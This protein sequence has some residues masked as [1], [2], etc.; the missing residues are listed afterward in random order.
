[1]KPYVPPAVITAAVAGLIVDRSHMAAREHDQQIETAFR[2]SHVYR[3]YLRH[4]AVNISVKEG[5]VFLTGTVSND[6]HRI[7]AEEMAAHLCGV[8]RVNNYLTTD[9]HKES[10]TPSASQDRRITRHVLATLLFH[11]SVSASSTNVEVSDGVVTL[12]GDATSEAQRELTAAYAL[13][14]DGVISIDNQMVVSQSENSADL[15]D[16]QNLDDASISAQVKMALVTHRSTNAL[17]MMI[18]TRAG[19]VTVVGIAKNAAEKSLISKLI[20]GIRGVTS[21]RNEITISAIPSA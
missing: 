20:R 16:G 6:V 10:A 13:D 15:S 18:R 19:R 1:M 3:T 5:V 14:I 11:R 8:T 2:R 12:S 21:V 4:D 9:A 7:L 17:E